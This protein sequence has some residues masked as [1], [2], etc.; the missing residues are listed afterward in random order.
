MV[1]TSRADP[2]QH[3]TATVTSSYSGHKRDMR[4]LYLLSPEIAAAD[5]PSNHHHQSWPGRPAVGDT[6]VD[7]DPARHTKTPDAGR[8]ADTT[9]S[10]TFNYPGGAENARTAAPSDRQACQCD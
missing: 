7:L 3:L 1:S 2:I 9:G 5:R 8:A 10:A 6:R 4:V